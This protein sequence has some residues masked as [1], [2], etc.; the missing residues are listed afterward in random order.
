[1]DRTLI[2]VFLTFVW[3]SLLVNR[4]LD[5]L[6]EIKRQAGFVQDQLALGCMTL[7]VSIRSNLESIFL[8][9]CFG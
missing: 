6:T 2:E 7:E 1:M 9:N 5:L 8:L 3:V 4:F